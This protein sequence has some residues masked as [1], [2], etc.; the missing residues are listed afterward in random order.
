MVLTHFTQGGHGKHESHQSIAPRIKAL[1]E[2]Q[3]ERQSPASDEPKIS[4]NEVVGRVAFFYERLRS[5]I[6]YKDEHLLRKSAIERILR[7]LLVLHQ[8][9]LAISD[10]L[11]REMIAARYLE[12][13]VIPETKIVS[14]AGII[15]KYLSVRTR[16]LE[17]YGHEPGN[18]LGDWLFR[19]MPVE[20][21]H[22]LAPSRP[23]QAF[24]KALMETMEE[25]VVLE[26]AHMSPGQRRAHLL[27]ASYRAFLK[28]D[29]SMLEYYLLVD[30]YPHWVG[31]STSAAIELIVHKFTRIHEGMRHLLDHP[32]QRP[33]LR[34]AQKLALLFQIL[35]Y[36]LHTAENAE[37]V[38]ASS[39]HLENTIRS[40]YRKLYEKARTKLRR[41]AFRSIIYIFLTKVLVALAL[42]YPYDLFIRQEVNTKALTINLILP[43]LIMFIVALFIRYPTKKNLQ[44]IVDGLQGLVTEGVAKGFN[45]RIRVPAHHGWFLQVLYYLF[46]VV[47]YLVTFGLIGVGLQWLRFNI[48]STL[49]FLFF[50][51]VVSFFGY[52]IRVGIRELIVEESHSFIAGIFELFALPIIRAGRWLSFNV[53]KI[54]IF[55][56]FFDVIIE[57]PLKVVLNLFEGFATFFREKKEEIDQ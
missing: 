34:L 47:L 24:V 57:A 1:L 50:L 52:R 14:V 46:Y 41:S 20:L 55:I 16:L 38:L 42:E 26:G 6:D 5:F 39:E 30:T 21:E 2:K 35:W 23:E 18:Q 28:S 13:N 49:L 11:I 40:T 7:R 54:N 33:I 51:T 53:S 45:Y 22:E 31:Q 15:A 10:H 37:A 12:N 48:V 3:I 27:L 19:L 44:K 29:N 4:V 56:F 9:P 25:Q 17:V 32:A 36:V 43:P 8:D